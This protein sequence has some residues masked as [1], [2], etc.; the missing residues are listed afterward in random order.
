M[1][2]T[3]AKIKKKHLKLQIFFT[4]S[5]DTLTRLSVLFLHPKY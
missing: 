2:K 1:K 5:K 4:G 3:E